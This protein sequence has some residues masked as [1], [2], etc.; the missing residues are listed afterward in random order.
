[1]EGG[2]WTDQLVD[3]YRPFDWLVVLKWKVEGNGSSSCFPL[4]GRRDLY[5]QW[6]A[7][8]VV[9]GLPQDVEGDHSDEETECD[10]ASGHVHALRDRIGE[11]LHCRNMVVLG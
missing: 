4:T 8:Q 9:D 10:R 3:G 5:V 1:M 6:T 11:R 2:Q 7:G